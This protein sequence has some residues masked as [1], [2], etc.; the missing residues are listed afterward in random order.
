MFLVEERCSASNLFL[1]LRGK[2]RAEK[3][4]AKNQTKKKFQE[5]W[6]LVWKDLTRSQSQVVCHLL[7]NELVACLG[8]VP[9]CVSAAG[10][11]GE[12]DA[13]R[14]RE[15]VCYEKR[16]ASFF[17]TSSWRHPSHVHKSTPTRPREVLCKLYATNQAHRCAVIVARQQTRV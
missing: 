8:R 9:Q 15:R 7:L 16:P 13:D 4:D 14:R 3:E 5:N 10:C 12:R 6:L 17:S 1:D 11:E 2:T